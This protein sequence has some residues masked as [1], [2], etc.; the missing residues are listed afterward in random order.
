MSLFVSTTD[1]NRLEWVRQVAFAL[2]SLL[3]SRA[4]MGRGPVV[5]KTADFTVADTEVWL[6]NNKS[7]SSCTVTLPNAAQWLGREI[8]ITNRQAQTVV[9]AASNVVPIAGG[10]AGTAILPATAGAWAT[11]VSD[12]TVWQT[13]QA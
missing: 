10:A 6:I 7:G 1:T 2:N 3:T 13:M 8:M 11:L 9:S 4:L 12:G 5:T